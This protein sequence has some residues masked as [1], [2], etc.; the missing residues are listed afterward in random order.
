MDSRV[1]ELTNEL[2]LKGF[3]SERVNVMHEETIGNLK[4][5]QLELE[6]KEKKLEVEAKGEMCLDFDL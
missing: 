4:K 2:R 6:K 1:S 5:C 3:D